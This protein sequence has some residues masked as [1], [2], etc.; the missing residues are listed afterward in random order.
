[1]NVHTTVCADILYAMEKLPGLFKNFIDEKMIFV[2]SNAK[3]LVFFRKPVKKGVEIGT[4][5]NRHDFA[6]NHG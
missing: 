2:L 4:I 5:V 3:R 1:M 6:Y